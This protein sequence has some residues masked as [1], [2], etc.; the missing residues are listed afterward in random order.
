MGTA[1]KSKN[2][3]NPAVFSEP[4]KYTPRVNP[5]VNYGLWVILMCQGRFIACPSVPLPWGHG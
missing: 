1:V 4:I 3:N 5:N 2:K